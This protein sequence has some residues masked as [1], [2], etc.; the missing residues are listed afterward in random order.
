MVRR[1]LALLVIAAAASAALGRLA[2]RFPLPR[3]DI[4]RWLVELGPADAAMSVLRAVALGAAVYLSAIS[5]LHLLVPTWS[6]ARRWVTRVT[7]P[8]LRAFL[9]GT[10]LATSSAGAAFAG[11]GAVPPPPVSIALSDPAAV[12]APS[13]PD[14]A[15]Y[16]VK[17]G[18]CFW[19]IAE[20]AITAH[21]GRP[22]SLTELGSYWRRV[23]SA[24]NERLV[25]PGVPDL[26]FPGQ[27]LLLPEP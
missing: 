21:L 14:A 13:A 16:T 8:S 20:V 24:N 9:V 10:T 17:P 3:R 2:A 23:V 1:S 22:P 4:S 12:A 27:A 5:L 7:L 6:G 15:L 18:D 19:S 25:H 11:A 26:I